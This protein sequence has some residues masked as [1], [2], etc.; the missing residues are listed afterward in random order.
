MERMEIRTLREGDAAAW[1]Q[2][3]LTALETEPFAFG[4]TADEHRALT[5]EALA[6]RFRDAPSSNAHL[7]AFDNG[8]L[9]GMTAL[10]RETGLKE[11]H[12]AHIYGVY[13]AP[14]HRGK[15]IARALLAQ[16]LDVARQDPSLEQVQ[17]TVST[18][19]HAAAQLYRSF[20]FEIF[21]TEPQALKVGST[22]VDD[23]HMVLRL[24]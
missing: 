20:G 19:Q 13:V 23:N 17:L 4:Q 22:Y 8:V 16:L 11:R 5:V 9:V 18:R 24:R 3:R 1:W 7:G 14:E 21:G 2:L 12:K 6:T 10:I 15:G